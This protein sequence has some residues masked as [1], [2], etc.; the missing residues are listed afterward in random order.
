MKTQVLVEVMSA[1]NANGGNYFHEVC[2]AGS[3]DLLL[4]VQPYMTE[5]ECHL[6]HVI[7][8]QGRQCI[9]VAIETQ[10][11]DVAAGLIRILLSM[12][13]DVNGRTSNGGFTVLHFAVRRKFYVIA[14]WLCMQPGIDVNATCY[15]NVTPYQFAADINDRQMMNILEDCGAYTEIPFPDDS[16]GEEQSCC[17]GYYK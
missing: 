12:G 5:E 13:A 9:H 4:R 10:K 7:D 8:N 11:E 14:E 16:H 1:R 15:G 2:H 3:S 17:C 6:L